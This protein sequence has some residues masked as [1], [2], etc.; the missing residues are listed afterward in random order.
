MVCLCRARTTGLCFIDATNTHLYSEG[1]G[2]QFPE[3][4]QG[5][6]RQHVPACACVWVLQENDGVLEPCTD[7][8]RAQTNEQVKGYLNNNT[9]QTDA[10]LH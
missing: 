3:D 7:I 4:V 10:G 5:L 1:F 8:S 6:F 9:R 2:V